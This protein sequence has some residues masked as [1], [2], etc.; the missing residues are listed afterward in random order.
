[1]R[2][3]RFV[4]YT[5]YSVISGF[6]SGIGVIVILVHIMPFIGWS[7]VSGGPLN[8]LKALPDAFQAVNMG[9]VA[10]AAVTLAVGIFWPDKMRK[11]LPPHPGCPHR[12]HPHRRSLVDQHPHNRRRADGFPRH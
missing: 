10:I 12:R 2:I 6:M 8:T 9:A 3:G 1:M 4:S 5:P 11:V 7:V